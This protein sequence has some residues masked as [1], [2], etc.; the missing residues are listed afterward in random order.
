MNAAQCKPD[1]TISKKIPKFH[2][3][4][5]QDW[6]DMSQNSLPTHLQNPKPISKKKSPPNQKQQPLCSWV[7]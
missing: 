6:L 4:C 2:A 1:N 5:S 3:F 7:S